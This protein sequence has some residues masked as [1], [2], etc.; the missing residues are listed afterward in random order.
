MSR[1]LVR[2]CSAARASN[3][4]S[5]VRVGNYYSR[6]PWFGEAGSPASRRGKLGEQPGGQDAECRGLL[7]ARPTRHAASRPRPP[8]SHRYRSM[9]EAIDSGA[10]SLR[11]RAVQQNRRSHLPSAN[12]SQIRSL[13]PIRLSDTG[14]IMGCGG[15]LSR[16]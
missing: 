5:H 1:E 4:V 8:A 12:T 16:V 6:P 9:R 7:T 15:K 10:L 2:H 3:L 11:S 13:E 14:V